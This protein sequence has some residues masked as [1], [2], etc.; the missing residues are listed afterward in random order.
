[1]SIL[2]AILRIFREINFAISEKSCTFA[3]E[4]VK[5]EQKQK[6]GNVNFYFY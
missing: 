2:F 6:L 5:N 1:M 4:N 3:A